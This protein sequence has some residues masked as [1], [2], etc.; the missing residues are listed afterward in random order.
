MYARVCRSISARGVPGLP[1]GH[2]LE[3]LLNRMELAV[4]SVQWLHYRTVLIGM[5][6]EAQ[7]ACI[8]LSLPRSGGR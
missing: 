5:Q 4:S 6:P 2:S 8:H 1:G 7:A 3:P